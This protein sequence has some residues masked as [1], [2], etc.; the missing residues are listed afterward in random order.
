MSRHPAASRADHERFCVI[1]GWAKV[2]SARGKTGTHHVTYELALRDGRVLR[3]R[4]SHPPD[5]TT[6]GAALWAHILRDQLEV[7]EEEFWTCL[8]TATP[9]DRGESVEKRKALPADLVFQLVHRFGVPEPEVRQLTKAQAVARLQK[10]WA[11][12]AE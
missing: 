11:R 1:G 4:N 3:T 7:P 2:R 10:C 12:E 6:Y 5:R 9:P 8:E